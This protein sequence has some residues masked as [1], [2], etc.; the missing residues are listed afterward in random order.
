MQYQPTL[1]GLNFARISVQ[2]FSKTRFG[3]YQSLEQP[4]LYQANKGKSV[5]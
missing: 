4:F 3:E 5:L 1:Y 2:S